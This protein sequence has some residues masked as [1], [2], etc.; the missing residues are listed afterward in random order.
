MNATY[1]AAFEAQVAELTRIVDVPASTPLGYGVDLACVEDLTPTMDEVDPY[2]TRAIGEAQAR[3]LITG[4]GQLPDDPNYGTDVRGMLNQGYTQTELNTLDTDI[5]NELIKDDRIVD[6]QA[7]ATFT[8][9]ETL[10]V[11]VTS[12]PQGLDETFAF[13]FYVTDASVLIEQLG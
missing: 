3:R 4:R 9:Q 8:N 10:R 7:T 1:S 6:C 12:T 11:A 2:T 13:T 5:H